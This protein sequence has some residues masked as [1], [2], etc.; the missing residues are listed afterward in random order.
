M[1]KKKLRQIFSEIL[2]FFGIIVAFALMFIYGDAKMTAIANKPA[3]EAAVE[4]NTAP[5]VY[6][7]ADLTAAVSE[8]AAPVEVEPVVEAEPEPEPEI[9]VQHLYTDADAK[10]LAQMAWGECRGV[11]SLTANGVTVTGTYQ[12][13]A[14]M[15]CAINRYDA[16]YEDS[17]A[18][19][20]AAPQQFYG[21]SAKHPVDAE[22]L[23]LAYD[24]LDRWERE[25]LHGGDVG[26]T[27]P[28]D[29]L[30]FAGDGQHNYFRDSYKGGT[31]YT[32]ELPDVYAEG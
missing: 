14:V 7:L 27:L 29:Y 3:E 22:L 10:A 24:V 26:R 1:S 32:W 16:G 18:E 9:I 5:A 12:K 15:W 31:R 13:A 21:Y 2:M 17:I 23:E 11:G 6:A 28:A 8:P 20:C 25:Q 4:I 19:V 30:F